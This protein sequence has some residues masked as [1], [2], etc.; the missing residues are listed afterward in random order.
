MST[1]V[2]PTLVS[3]IV[4]SAVSLVG[5]SLFLLKG[6]T[7]ERFLIPLISISTGALLGDVF[8]HII[9]EMAE[10]AEIFSSTLLIILVGIIVSFMIEKT[11]HWRH[12]H[13]LP[14]EQHYH[15][16]GIL[17]LI[18]DGIHNFVDGA[19]IAGSFLVSIPVGIAT[20]VAVALHEIP[21]EIG[22]CAILLYSG[23][24][25]RKVLFFNFLSA[26]TAIIGAMVILIFSTSLPMIGTYALPFAAGNFL[27]IAG[28]DLIPELH[29]ETR[30][31][32][33]FLQLLCMVGGILLMYALTFLE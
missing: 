30:L 7:L 31:P 33:A 16:M 23:Y 6:N 32:H 8:I 4:V 24:E 5:I 28:A 13:V 11:V 9:P 19:L 3:V 22:D 29:K 18:G 20:T 2:F 26:C 10:E 1:I 15:P 14:S 17:N 25:K 27:Y 12:C 21:Q